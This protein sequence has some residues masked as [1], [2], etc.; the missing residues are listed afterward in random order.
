MSSQRSVVVIAASAHPNRVRDLE[1]IAEDVDRPS[2]LRALAA[3][4]LGRIEHPAAPAALLRQLASREPLVRRHAVRRLGMVGD[5][6]AIEP[7]RSLA[8]RDS[9]ANRDRAH[10]A[11]GLVEHR[12]GRSSSS[13]RLP[14]APPGVG[15]GDLA[16]ASVAVTQPAPR[17]VETCIMNLAS[18]PCGLV[19][20]E[21]SAVEVRIDAERW[22]V[23]PGVR[24]IHGVDDR[25]ALWGA[26]AEWD[27]VPAAHFLAGLILSSPATAAS[28]PRLHL[29]DLDGVLLAL[30]EAPC[31]ANGY[32]ASLRTVTD[33]VGLAFAFEG[34]IRDRRLAVDTARAALVETR[35]RVAVELPRVTATAAP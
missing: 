28:P 19:Y 10:F 21:A 25:A 30:G 1:A 22:I 32:A 24:G 3:E 11:A 9:G 14:D 23:L 33:A 26:L 17:A 34:R 13:I 27:A 35:K 16:T 15:V 31:A 8:Q 7:L 29:H 5:A 2:E 6:T 4:W 18:E 12:L 20:D